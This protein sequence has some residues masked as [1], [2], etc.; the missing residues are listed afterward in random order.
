MVQAELQR[1][2]DESTDL[3]GLSTQMNEIQDTLAGGMVSRLGRALLD[4]NVRHLRRMV[5]PPSS[6]LPNT[7]LPLSRSKLQSMDHMANKQ[8]PMSHFRT[9]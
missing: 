8:P 2:R 7:A 3:N 9:N 5:L 6:F 4:T 1:S